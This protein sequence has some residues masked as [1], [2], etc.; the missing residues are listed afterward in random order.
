MQCQ[1]QASLPRT[2]LG[3][4]PFLWSRVLF[5]GAAQQAQTWR[6][7]PLLVLLLASGALLYPSLNMHLFE[8]DEGRYAQIPREMLE[9]GDWIVPTLQGQPYLDKPPLFYWLVMGCYQLF[10]FHPWVARLVPALAVQ[11]TILATYLFGRRL[12]GER[13]AFW[14]ALLLTLMSG[15]AGMGRILV[16]DGLL[17]FWVTLSVFSG[18]CAVDGPR[19]RRGW[20]LVTALTAGL[21][22]LTKGPIALILL[23]PPL[24]LHRRLTATAAS[25]TPRA[26]LLF[27]AVVLLITLPWYVAVSL[28]VPDF[29]GHFLLVHN[30]QR[31]VEPFDHERPVW[32]F[33]PIL[34]GGLLPATFLLVPFVRFLLSE[35]EDDAGKRCPFLGY[36]FLTAG[37]CVL[38]FSLSG[39]KLPTY[40]LPAFPPLAL[41]FGLFLAQTSWG[42]ARWVR[43][44][45]LA[46]WA[47]GV[48]GHGVLLPMVARERS[49]WNDPARVAA[50]CED[51]RVPVVC[52]PRHVDS[53][54]FHLGRSDFR[55]FRSKNLDKLL[56]ELDRTPRTV[57]LFAHRNSLKTLEHHLPPHLC[58]RDAAPMGLCNIAVVEHHRWTKQ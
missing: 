33:L 35:K 17:T 25:I 41:A 38:F 55:A 15:F 54:A 52:F 45:C 57:V 14:G 21:G 5:P 36:L 1:E 37:W 10:G 53:V 12:A 30:F 39:C 56:A 11:G 32:F 28:Q 31:F 48:L 42:S 7:M 47:L 43:G 3:W 46:W 18:F 19:L 26:W 6:W 34:L 13:T 23:L 44:G 50:L 9:R 49:P 2:V 24:W 29:A 4:V 51:R 58:L 20:W 40:I 22:V 27:A 16:L 8:P